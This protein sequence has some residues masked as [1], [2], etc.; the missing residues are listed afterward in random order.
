MPMVKTDAVILFMI[1]VS[2]VLIGMSGA[3]L[4]PFAIDSGESSIWLACGRSLMNSRAIQ[5][6][7]S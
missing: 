3:A 2:S 5:S 4:P 1:V 7:K 6:G